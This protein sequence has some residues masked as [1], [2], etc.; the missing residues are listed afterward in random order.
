MISGI[1]LF[2]V[3]IFHCLFFSCDSQGLSELLE[4]H[5]LGMLPSDPFLKGKSLMFLSG[6]LEN[7][8]IKGENPASEGMRR[9]MMR[10]FK[11]PATRKKQLPLFKSDDQNAKY[12]D[13]YGFGPGLIG[14]AGGQGNT[15][16]RPR[17]YNYQ[18]HYHPADD[19]S[20]DEEEEKSGG[21]TNNIDISREGERTNNILPNF[22]QTGGLP[23]GLSMGILQGLKNG[24][25]RSLTDGLIQS[26][27]L[28]PELP[29]GLTSGL[30][31]GLGPGV[32]RAGQAPQEI[33]D[34]LMKMS[35]G[36]KNMEH[37]LRILKKLSKLKNRIQLLQ[38]KQ[39]QLLK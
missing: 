4:L 19:L 22:D 24:L 37:H 23:P 15:I 25:A 31:E 11:G 17:Q 26:N 28:T 9:Q 6:L 16:I 21:I 3:F 39:S 10:S 29:P 34:T 33:K 35:R 20:E 32:A 12:K 13:L 8:R 5:R 1:F 27:G 2:L 7:G 14:F 38:Y 30:E 18:I 36:L